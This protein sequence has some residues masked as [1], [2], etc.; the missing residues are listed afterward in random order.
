MEDFLSQDFAGTRHTPLLRSEDVKIS[1]VRRNNYG[2][3]TT[4]REYPV[5]PAPGIT[6]IRFPGMQNAIGRIVARE[7]RSAGGPFVREPPFPPR[8]RKP[9]TLPKASAP[10][11][12]GENAADPIW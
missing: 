2:K 8:F 6:A 5:L 11:P 3:K 10:E 9:R 1:L 4:P 7:R 12:L